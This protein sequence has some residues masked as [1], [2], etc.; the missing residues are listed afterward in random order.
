LT[1]V[2]L[3]AQLSAGAIV[4]HAK[5]VDLQV[6]D[7][8][9]RVHMEIVAEGVAKKRVF[10]LIM[11][12]EGVDYRAVITLV[13]PAA[14]E[15]TRLLIVAQRGK[16]N[17]QWAYFPDLDLVRPIAGR[18]Q[19]DPFLGSDVSYAD[20]AGAAHLDDL[21]HRLVGEEVIDGTPCYVMEGVPRHRIAYGKLRGWVRKDDFVTIRA[22]FFDEDLD[23]LKEARL[24]DIREV[25]GVPMAHR[26]EMKSLIGESKTVLSLSE[27]RINQDLPP[28]L[29][30]E[31]ALGVSEN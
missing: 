24:T 27:L 28:G 26:I 20:L 14:M 9:A 30:T 13:E 29:F 4:A 31:A 25:S 5:E 19:D 3:I 15:G 18:N 8:S 12:R 1:A 2:L 22:V 11:R 21:L 10:E 17:R 23:P 16:R 7:L 6:K